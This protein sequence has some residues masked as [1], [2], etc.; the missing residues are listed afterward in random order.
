[1]LGKI[2]SQK[3][4]FDSY[5][6]EYFLPREHKLLKIKEKVNSFFIEEETKVLYSEK[7]G[8]PSYPPEII[9][10]ILFL[11][12]YYHFSDTE[13]IK[14]LKFNVLFRYFVGLKA[15]NSI[16]GTS[17]LAVFRKRLGEERLK[18]IF[19]KFVKQC[20]DKG[21]LEKVEVQKKI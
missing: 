2:N 1:M 14:Q 20:K 11:K 12:F 5:I 4:F 13:V 9:F 21:L 3:N 17:S 7:K 10:K 16:P 8:R 19:D 15:E 6:E 18:R